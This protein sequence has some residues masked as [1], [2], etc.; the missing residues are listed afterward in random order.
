MLIGQDIYKSFNGKEILHGV[1]IEIQTGKISVLIGPSGGGKT[2]LVRAL[3][4]IDCPTQGHISFN[5]LDY[6][7]PLGDKTRIS[8]PWPE[9]TVV[10]QQHF[11]WPHLTLRQNIELP[12]QDNPLVPH[13]IEELINI[14]RMEEFIDHYPNQASLGQRQRVAL[15]RAFA[16]KPK[17]ILLDEITSALDVEQTGAVIRHLLLLRSRGIGMLVVTHLLEFARQ[18]VS[19]NEGDMVFFLDEG[20]IAG[21]GGLDFFDNPDTARARQFLSSMDYWVNHNEIQ[22]NQKREKQL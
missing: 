14:F 5:G 4:L 7:F 2:T 8:P 12:L 10:F 13:D 3:S 16:L 1:N 11:L 19:R 22:K 21:A 20:R 6:S 18:L 17:C 15:A 9:L